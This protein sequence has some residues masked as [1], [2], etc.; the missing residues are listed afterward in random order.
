MLRQLLLLEL[1]GLLLA[2]GLAAAVVLPPSLSIGS[3]SFR[4]ENVLLVFALVTLLRYVF[5]HR[6]TPYLQTMAAKGVACILV[7]P[8]FLFAALT[9]NQF[10][11]RVDELGF[12]GL[13]LQARGPRAAD[14]GRYLR[15]EAI[16]F[17]TGVMILCVVLPPVFIRAIWL[18]NKQRLRR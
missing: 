8:L 1:I 12:D 4:L 18:Q 17:G 7:V 9:V 14:W 2:A 10:Q 11:T 13:F 5:F 16:F 6:Q 3:F 15:N